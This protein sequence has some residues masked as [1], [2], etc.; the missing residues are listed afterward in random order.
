D[1]LP[2]SYKAKSPRFGKAYNQY[3]FLRIR[4]VFLRFPPNRAGFHCPFDRKKVCRYHLD[5]D[6]NFAAD[7]LNRA[8]WFPKYS[9][10]NQSDRIWYNRHRANKP[11]Q[12]W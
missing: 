3:L 2:I 11:F 12:D 7:P 5:V 6:A 9:N 4:N 10:S 1:A 8:E